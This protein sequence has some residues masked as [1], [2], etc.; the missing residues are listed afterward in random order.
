MAYRGLADF[1]LV[2]HALFVAFV[3]IGLLLIVAGL[4]LNWPWVRNWWFRVA[5]LAAIGVVVAQ[6][7]LGVICPLTIWENALRRRGGEEAY[8]DSFIQHWLH[9]V[10][11]YQAE[12]WVFT[13]AYSLFGAL[14]VATWVWGPPRRV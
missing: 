12:P 4:L 2:V 3:V 10:I 11:F 13:L 7:W 5:H 1:I 6:A 9:K 8:A 14:V